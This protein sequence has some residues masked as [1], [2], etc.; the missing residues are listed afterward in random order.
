MIEPRAAP[1]CRRAAVGISDHRPQQ[2]RSRA[3][4]DRTV[5]ADAAIA[6]QIA[7]SLAAWCFCDLL[8]HSTP[9]G[10]QFDERLVLRGH[11]SYQVHFS[12]SQCYSER[13]RLAHPQR[14]G[15]AWQLNPA[16][17]DD[18]PTSTPGASSCAAAGALSRRRRS[19]DLPYSRNIARRCSERRRRRA[20][21]A[22]GARAARRDRRHCG[23]NR[24]CRRCSDAT[25]SEPGLTHAVRAV[26]GERRHT[27]RQ[28]TLRVALR[29]LEHQRLAP[30]RLD[31]RG[32][33]LPLDAPPRHR[34]GRARAPP[35]RRRRQTGRR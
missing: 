30:R 20:E 29:L 33:V 3:S 25:L 26:G 6:P 23:S 14:G 19:T 28:D 1:C 9:Q 22:R 17:N 8:L 27:S 35:P 7:P 21:A 2:T 16:P 18:M 11:A 12:L 15:A 5:K 24:R 31:Q 34:P 13:S 32:A 10:R 4:G